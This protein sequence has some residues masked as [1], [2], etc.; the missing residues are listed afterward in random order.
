MGQESAS[1][2]YSEIGS[3][4]GTLPPGYRHDRYEARLAIGGPSFQRAADGLRT[5]AAHRGA[6]VAVYPSA[7]PLAEGTTVILVIS[8]ALVLAIAACRIVYTVAEPRLF[9]FPYGTLALHPEQ[10]EEAFIVERDQD[11]SV[12][13]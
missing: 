3:T 8:F 13:F 7:A 5:W 4:A 12:W 11:H 1:L 2:S 9:G 10:G 6:G